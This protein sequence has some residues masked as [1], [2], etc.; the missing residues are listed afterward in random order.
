M[1]KCVSCF[2]CQQNLDKIVQGLNKKLLGRNI[3]K[4]LCLNCL[5]TYLE[6]TTEDLL[7]RAEEFKAQ[8]CSLF[9]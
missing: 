5:A 3:K 9:L 1:K 4:Y 7:A 6:V 8:G 2:L